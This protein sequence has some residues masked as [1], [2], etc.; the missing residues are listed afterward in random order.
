MSGLGVVSRRRIADFALAL[1][2]RR[3]HLGAALA[4]VVAPSLACERSCIPVECAAQVVLPVTVPISATPSGGTLRVCRLNT[5]IDLVVVGY[6]GVAGAYAGP[7]CTVAGSADPFQLECSSAN[8]G[9]DRI[10]RIL[11]RQAK[12]SMPTERFTVSGLFGSTTVALAFDV[13]YEN[14]CTSECGICE[15]S[16]VV[17]VTP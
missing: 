14:V 4:A 7:E 16:K 15:S 17:A 11:L 9:S 5:C 2:S 8:S 6:S 1:G 12:P 10:L 3:W 13:T